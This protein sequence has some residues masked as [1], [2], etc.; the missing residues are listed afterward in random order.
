MQPVTDTPPDIAAIVHK[1]LM[2]LS[3]AERV[4]MGSMSFDAARAIVLASLPSDLPAAELKRRLYERI[5][6]EPLP[7]TLAG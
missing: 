1:R 5:Y 7:A 6:G 4:R 2:A 3:S